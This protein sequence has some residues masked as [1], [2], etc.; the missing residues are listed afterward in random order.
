MKKKP[1]TFITALAILVAAV[2]L[3]MV[4]AG[5]KEPP[6]RKQK[7]EQ[8]IL[9]ATQSVENQNT[10]ARVPVIGNI[11]AKNKIE[12][13]TEV[14]GVLLNNSKQFLEGVTFKKGESLV[15]INSNEF[16]QTLKAQKSGFMNQLTQV[17][18][19]LKIDYPDAYE[20]FK[21]F[22]SDFQLDGHMPPLP[23]ATT[24]QE[25][26]FLAGRNIYKFYYDIAALEEKLDKYNLEAPFT[27][28]VTSSLIKPGTLVRAGQKLGE[29]IDTGVYD[30]ETHIKL[31]EM[32]LVRIGDTVELYSDDVT[33]KWNGTVSRISDSIDNQTRTLKIFVSVSGATLKEGM[34]LKGD[35][36]SDL[37]VKTAEIPRKLL[38]EPDHVMVVKG[39]EI[40]LAQVKVV[41][42]KDET[43]LVEGLPNGAQLPSKTS[44]L[45]K[46]MTV[47]VQPVT[48]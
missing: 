47:R 35:V 24:D 45:S 10:N 32:N 21:T 38:V 9:V 23:Q 42:Y 19:D 25:K 7:V 12:V 22:L 33:G 37:S 8:P 5:M 6:K 31:E 34:Y 13:Y 44:G 43:V 26:Y 39:T 4:L 18:P 15:K 41:Q 40:D 46:G 48:P 30:L 20:R 1:F 17:L 36:V 11:T 16:R 28:V 29:F 3:T 2:G 27:G 14:N